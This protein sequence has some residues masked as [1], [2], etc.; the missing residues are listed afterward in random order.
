VKKMSVEEL[1]EFERGIAEEVKEGKIKGA[2]HL[3]GGNEKELVQIFERVEERDWVISTHRNHYHYLLK[4]GDKE[5][6]REHI[7]GGGSMQISSREHR[8]FSTAILAGGCSIGCGIAAAEKEKLGLLE[9]DDPKVLVFVGD[10][11]AD[12][13][14][15]MHAVEYAYYHDLNVT[16]V[17]ED[18]NYS[19]DTP[20]AARWNGICDR[21]KRIAKPGK[22]GRVIYYNYVRTYPHVGLGGKGGL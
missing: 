9:W 20:V 15:F 19:C 7:R 8:F 2:V 22:F 18:N 16:W 13:G 11:A 5:G 12:N 17:L 3:C 1:I 6:L 10:G 14:K 4:T 21:Y